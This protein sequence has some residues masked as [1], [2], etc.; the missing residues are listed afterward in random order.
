MTE[1][2][3][4]DVAYLWEADMRGGA[5]GDGWALLD[6]DERARAERMK[7]AGRRR[8][9]VTGRAFLRTALAKLTDD[10]A[11]ELRFSYGK[12]GKPFL[13]G[14]PS[15]NLSHSGERLLVAV[16]AR[17]RVGVDVERV[18]PVR[19]LEAVVA[20][21]F[22]AGERRWLAAAGEGEREAAFFRLWTRKEAFAKAL[23][24]GLAIPFRSFSVDME[25]GE[26][27]RLA[28]LAVPGERAD[29]W[30][31]MGLPAE[32]GTAAALAADWRDVVV[33]RLPYPQHCVPVVA[34]EQMA[35][36]T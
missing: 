2:L 29:D 4:P 24:G 30:S 3:R 32:P 27:G 8:R 20:R 1:A 25:A 22:A 13:P 11:R 5:A 12:H 31:V 26:D 21:R 28:E 33:E 9:F 17:G 36:L 19:R 10:D 6:A 15:F 14:G 16:A 18:R 23:G 35:P 34:L 7:D